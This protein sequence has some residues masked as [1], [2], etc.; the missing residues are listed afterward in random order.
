ML[1]ANLQISPCD[2]VLIEIHTALTYGVPIVPLELQ[3][4]DYGWK[5]S[6][7][8]QWPSNDELRA[9]FVKEYAD[10][11]GYLPRAL[12][13]WLHWTIGCWNDPADAQAYTDALR[14][15]LSMP[16]MLEYKA[17]ATTRVST[18]QDED[19]V[20]RIK[21]VMDGP[22]PDRVKGYGV[23]PLRRFRVAGHAVRSAIRLQK[24][25]TAPGRLDIM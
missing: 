2:P 9:L 23:D 11:D 8:P 14:E 17:T 15:Q 13:D 24:R 10:E 7:P 25:N 21:A 16:A 19:L 12:D 3:H 22:R 1:P 5:D 6:G 18:A 4:R 20:Q